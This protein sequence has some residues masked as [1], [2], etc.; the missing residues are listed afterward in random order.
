MR[1]LKPRERA[2]LWLAYAQGWSHA[3][4]AETLGLRK[5]RLKALLWRARRRLVRLMQQG[6][7][8]GG[9]R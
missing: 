3:E 2:L 7:A 1:R 6:G 8:T 4:I 5:A 9:R